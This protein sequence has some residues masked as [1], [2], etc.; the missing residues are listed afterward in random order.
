MPSGRFLLCWGN[1]H[2]DLRHVGLWIVADDVIDK[3]DL[4]RGAGGRQVVFV[5]VAQ[6]LLVAWGCLPV[7]A[8][9]TYGQAARGGSRLNVAQ[10][11]IGV[12]EQQKDL[13]VAIKVA[14]GQAFGRDTHT[15]IAQIGKGFV[16]PLLKLA[17]MPSQRIGVGG[18]DALVQRGSAKFGFL[19]FANGVEISIQSAMKQGKPLV[20]LARHA[21]Q[22]TPPVLN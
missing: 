6:Q 19:D 12:I 4:A 20:N 11:I 13:V 21:L 9:E 8:A 18:I 3:G 5:H 15:Q 10:V 1:G 16:L 22:L 7:R 2:R 17:D 14:G